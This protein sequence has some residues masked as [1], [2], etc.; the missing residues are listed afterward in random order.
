LFLYLFI[1]MIQIFTCL[2]HNSGEYANFL[3]KNLLS[4]ADDKNNLKFSAIADD[5][6]INNCNVE[7]EILEVVKTPHNL[8]EGYGAKNHAT[9]LNK[10]INHID[11]NSQIVIICDCDVAILKKGWDTMIENLHK[12][13]DVLI[14]PK[15]SGRSSVYFT[16]FTKKSYLKVIPDFTPGTK[17]NDNK[18]TTVYEDTGYKIQD[19]F[20][21][22]KIML[23]NLD[24][25]DGESYKRNFENDGLFY[26]Y[27]LNNQKFITHFGGSHKKNF[28]SNSTKKWIDNVNKILENE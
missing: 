19:Q 10:I 28:T 14:T 22:H 27:M 20:K 2:T 9:M 18:V 21:N 26:L 3:K 7:W 1:I 23:Y 12:K 25:F 13:Y 5:K 24:G 15:F 16:S 11:N 6:F 8:F 4:S 17:E